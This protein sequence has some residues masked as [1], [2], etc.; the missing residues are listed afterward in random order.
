MRHAFHLDGG[1]V[2]TMAHYT[3]ARSFNPEVDYILDIGGQDI[4]C[5]KI[6][7]GHIDDIVLNEACSSGCGSFI[8]TFAKSLG[9]D[10]K[11]FATLG[12]KSKHPVDLGTRC[13][14]FMNSGV[15]QAQKNGASIED[16]SAGLCKSVVKN[17]LYKVIRAKNKDDIGKH[18]VVQGGTFQN[19]S[20]LRCFEQELGLEVIRPSIAPL[21]GAYGAAL[22]AKNYIVLEV[23][24]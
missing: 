1:I 9:Y 18:I 15:K 2:E 4:K 16:I 6:R 5:F 3:A 8:E 11:E 21:M 13:T 24:F 7:D 14:V 17:A 22:Y 19:D 12:L 10:A 20:V 23:I